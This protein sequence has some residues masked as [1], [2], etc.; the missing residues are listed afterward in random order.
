MTGGTVGAIALIMVLAPSALGATFHAPYTGVVVKGD[1][2]S[3]FGCAKGHG[4]MAFSLST[5]N[6]TASGSATAKTCAKSI[7][8]IGKDSSAYNEPN[9][10]AAVNVH[11]PSGAHK[12]SANWAVNLA[13]KGSEL[14]GACP[15]PIPFKDTYTYH[16][17]V[18][19]YWDNSTGASVYCAADAAIYGEIYGY[20][21]DAP[22]GQQYNYSYHTFDS[23]MDTYNDSYWDC[24]NDT[25][26]NGTGYHYSTGCYGSNGTVHTYA[27]LGGVYYS[28]WSG[29]TSF[30]N[31]T[32]AAFSMYANQTFIGTHHYAWVFEIY[33]E[34]SAYL[35]TWHGTSSA[36]Y[37]MATLGN[38]AHLVKITVV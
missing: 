2:N 10:E 29:P 9:I 35:E 32:S 12:V 26:W 25:Y 11:L 6:A 4:S 7:G 19:Y 5:G 22:T 24:Y 18:Y 28:A 37:N 34:A 13:E 23:Y 36:S 31:T 8:L 15:A 38:G 1:Y 33:F 30:S 17:G 14:F 16:Y 21:L 27:Y 3:V 20:L